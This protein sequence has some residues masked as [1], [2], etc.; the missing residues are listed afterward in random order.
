LSKVLIIIPCSPGAEIGNYFAS[1]SW[2]NV[3]RI[4]K[5]YVFDLGNI[6]FAAVDS[7]ITIEDPAKDREELGAIVLANE[8]MQRV[9]G[10]NIRP[11]WEFF[12]KNN[13]KKLYEHTKYVEIGLRRVLNK[14]DYI[15]IFLNVRAY[16]LATMNALLRIGNGKIPS[17][18]L[19]IEC[20]ESPGWLLHCAHIAG[21]FIRDYLKRKTKVTGIFIPN[22]IKSRLKK[23]YECLSYIPNE[24]RYW[25]V[26]Q[27]FI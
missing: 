20:L 3:V 7:I 16:K 24:F 15:V 22:R 5:K 8:E 4:I 11:K 17:N 25:E 1:A 9:R 6:D 21:S 26:L 14:Y 10:K 27:L 12:A 23:I 18:V 2:R 13:Y 19:Y